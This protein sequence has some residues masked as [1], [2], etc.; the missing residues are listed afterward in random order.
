MPE[1]TSPSPFSSDRPRRS[2]GAISTRAMSRIS[3]GVPPLA[4]DDQLL[5]VA[6][7]AQVARPRT[8]YSVSAISTTRP[9]TSRLESRITCDTFDQ[10]DAVAA[11]LERIDGDLVGLHEAA[12]RGHLGHARGLG[13]LVAHVPVLDRAQLGQGLALGQQRRTG[14][15]SRRRWR[16]ARARATRPWA[17]GWRRSSGT[18]APGCAPSRC[19][20]RPRRSRRRRRRRRTRSRARPWTW[21]PRAS[22]WSAGRSPGLR[23]PAAPGRGTRCRR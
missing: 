15:P 9:P 6:L 21:A 18:R 10:R 20:C 3:T 1:T 12:E 23:P 2:S 11:Q 14:R 5:D 8:M 13:Q 16:R 17:D 4:L 19:R 7:A 22:R